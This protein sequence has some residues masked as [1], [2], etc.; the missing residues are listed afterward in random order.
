MNVSLK[1]FLRMCSF[2]KTSN[3]NCSL[4]RF[5]PTE[6]FPTENQWLVN[7]WMEGKHRINQL[8]ESWMGRDSYIMT[9]EPFS[10]Q[11]WVIPPCFSLLTLPIDHL[12][13]L[14]SSS[15]MDAPFFILAFIVFSACSNTKTTIEQFES[16]PK[17][18][19][20]IAMAFANY[21]WIF[22]VKSHTGSSTLKT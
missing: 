3:T 7:V 20:T 8:A 21:G 11:S 19:D 16:F 4:L 5:K 12:F 13:S 9:P 18:T 15:E 1:V 6:K 22:N 17:T 10:H 14:A 2:L